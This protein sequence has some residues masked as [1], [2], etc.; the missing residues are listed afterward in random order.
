[1]RSRKLRITAYVNAMQIAIGDVK[2]VKFAD[3]RQPETE[4]VCPSCGARPS[5]TGGYQCTCGQKYNH[6]SRLKRILKA[7][8]QEILKVKFTEDKQAIEGQAFVLERKVFAE[9]YSDAILEEKGIVAE[10]PSTA[11]NVRNLLIAS[12]M[13]DKV[14]VVAFKD[15]YEERTCLLTLSE[16]NRVLLREIIPQNIL[17]LEETMRADVSN[18]SERDIEAAKKF[19]ELL[20]PPTEDVFLCHDYRAV[21]VGAA[22]KPS[23]KV[24]ELEAILRQAEQRKLA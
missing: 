11:K 9:R 5:W 23:E 4:L 1:M 10:N 8:G 24:V 12:K 3:V 19:V 6:W 17:E 18:V 14:V 15:T 22:E 20:P 21:G 7:T 2:I 16:S 13:L